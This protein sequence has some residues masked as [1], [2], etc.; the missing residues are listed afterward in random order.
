MNLPT[1]T[2]DD[3][4]RAHSRRWFLKE[5]GLGLGGIALASLEARA[6]TTNPLAPKISPQAAKAKKRYL[7]FH[8]RRAQP[9]RPF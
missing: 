1:N 9:S 6:N 4:Q 3:L 2:L 7:P 8:G 5:C